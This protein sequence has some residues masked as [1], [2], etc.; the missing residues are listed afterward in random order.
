[1]AA[2]L[3]EWTGKLNTLNTQI[4]AERNN[5]CDE[6]IIAQL[7][8]VADH[9]HVIADKFKHFLPILNALSNEGMRDRHWESVLLR[10]LVNRGIFYALV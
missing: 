6:N 1:M 3:D 2:R 7:N 4:N 5:N 9:V 10:K 8:R